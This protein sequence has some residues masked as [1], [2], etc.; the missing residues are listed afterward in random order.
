MYRSSS[1]NSSSR[2]TAWLHGLSAAASK[3]NAK[4]RTVTADN[5]CPQRDVDGAAIQVNWTAGHSSQMSLRIRFYIQWHSG[6][7]FRLYHCRCLRCF[8]TS[9]HHPSHARTF[10]LLMEDILIRRIRIASYTSQIN[11]YRK[12]WQYKGFQCMVWWQ[13]ILQRT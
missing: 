1:G 11:Q 4:H 3:L 13:I 12:M 6:R 10:C 8:S 2:C 7:L 5:L 9:S